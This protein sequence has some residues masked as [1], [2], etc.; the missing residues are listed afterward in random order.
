[1]IKKIFFLLS[2]A[3]CLLVF[4]SC[5]SNSSQKISE[6]KSPGQSLF[7][8]NCTNCHGADG[9]LC[10]LGAKDLSASSMTKEQ[11]IE[12]ISNGKNTMAPFGN[13]LKKEEISNVADYV[14]TLKK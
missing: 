11:M 5:E 14:Q 6:V 1:M 3:Y 12:I 10:A 7:K 9:K 8:T 2:I 4:S 13:M